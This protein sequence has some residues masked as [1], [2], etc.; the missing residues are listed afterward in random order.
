MYVYVFTYVGTY[1]Y[2]YVC[3]YTAIVT[4]PA[5]INHLVSQNPLQFF[6]YVAMSYH[7]L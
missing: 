5:V 2:S 3:M 6:K 7:N 4:V 1:V